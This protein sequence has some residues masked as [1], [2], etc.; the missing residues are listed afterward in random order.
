MTNS[1]AQLLADAA[2][3]L[4]DETALV[5]A[6]SGRRLTWRELDADVDAVAAGLGEQGLVA[7]YRVVV[8]MGNRI[9]FVTAYLGTLRAQLVAVPINPRSTGAEIAHVL[10]DCGA[11]VVLADGSCVDAVRDAMT[12]RGDVPAPRVFVVDA[13]PVG[14]ERPWADLPVES[15]GAL[16]APLD[17][18]A[19]AALLYTSG[20]SGRPR[21]AMLTHRALLANIEQ[22]AAVEPPMLAPGDVVLGLLPL[23]H[24]YGLNAVLGA[25]LRMRARLVLTDGFHP[26]G[27]LD[28]VEDE[29]ISVLPV[30][31]PVFPSWLALDDLAE[32]FGPVRVV[33]SGS[34]TMPAETVEE[35]QAKAKVPLHQGY[36]LTE[37]APVV[38][39]TLCQPEPTLG[40]LGAVLPGVGLR[41]KDEDGHPPEGSD[42]G[43]V[44]IRGDNLFSG[45]WPDGDE[46][47]DEDGWWPTGDVGFLEPD[48]ALTLVDRRK[49]L[50]VVSGFNVYPSEVEEAIGEVAGVSAA[51]VVGAPDEATGE[52]VVA[53]VVSTG[54]PAQVEQAVREHAATRLA[55]FKQ[56]TTIHVVDEL[57]LTVT[58]K[59]QRGRLR[60][61]A[62]R[63]AAP[64]VEEPR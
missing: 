2:R 16:P 50:V 41:L 36:G 48:G 22:I 64:L 23:F 45:Y 21:G 52:A 12:E 27:T 61:A 34:A 63:L 13:D 5:D 26:T 57:P 53:Y 10:T 9:E 62:R 60:A 28:L 55:R 59:V 15:A 24:V 4:P 38:T 3:D 51:A 44:E 19:L 35:F 1:V 43:D 7:G 29:A 17:R 54:D 46:A 56:P 49:N 47:P 25:T 11:R 8:A 18:E 32:R 40:S 39:S 58:G 33:L 37:A 6:T 20:A 14:D 42:P 31:P 30:A